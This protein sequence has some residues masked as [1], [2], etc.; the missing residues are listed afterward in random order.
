MKAFRKRLGESNHE[1]EMI[2]FAKK[3]LNLPGRNT[4]LTKLKD[5]IGTYTTL[6][7]GDFKTS[8]VLFGY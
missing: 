8:T 5:Y 2:T 4:F 7:Y 1:G 6:S 3:T